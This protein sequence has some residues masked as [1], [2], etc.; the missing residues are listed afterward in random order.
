MGLTKLRLSSSLVRPEG[1]AEKGEKER[2][3][4]YRKPEIIDR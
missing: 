2:M 3:G 1:R 4:H